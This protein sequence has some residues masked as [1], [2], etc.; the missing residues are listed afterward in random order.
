MT[1]QILTLFTRTPLHVGAGSSVGAIDQPVVRERHTRFPVI[2]GSSIKGVLADAWSDELVKN[3]KGRLVRPDDDNTKEISWLFGAEDA[4][5]ANAGALL[6]GEARLLAFPVR[7]ARAGFAWVTSPVAINRA[8][9]D[10]LFAGLTEIG[11]DLGDD[12]A[13]FSMEAL[14][15][16][17]EVILEDQ[18]LKHKGMIPVELADAFKTVP[19]FANNLP[20]LVVVADGT[21]SYFTTT[22][23]EVAQHVKIDDDTGTA[24]GKFLFNQENVP[25]DT[26]FY[27][28]I[29]AVSRQG[30]AAPD[31]LAA[32]SRK[33]VALPVWQ[34]G[35]DGSTGLG[36]CTVTL[37]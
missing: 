33:L 34:F 29:H 24:A 37:K 14:G 16:R 19:G 10:G 28:P 9:R 5:A 18:P 30:K 26:F 6:F 31:A 15:I 11:D 21:L 2:P 25:A 35:G 13:R 27:A 3:D 8:I 23:C 20:R 22:A 32:L 17:N 36:Y 7:S 12:G 4:S 1:T